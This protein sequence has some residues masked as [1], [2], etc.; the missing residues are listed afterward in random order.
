MSSAQSTIYNIVPIHKSGDLIKTDNYR[1]ISPTSVMVKVYNRMLLNRIKPI[2][3]PLQRTNQY[4]F[5]ETRTTVQQ[6]LALRRL[7]EGVKKKQLSAIIT[8]IALRKAFES[9]HR[10]RLMRIL[11]ADGIPKPIIDSVSAMYA[12]TSAKVMSPDGVTE[13]FPILAG[14]LQGDTLV[15]YLSII[16]L[17]YTLRRAIEGRKEQLG[18]TVTPRKR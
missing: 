13:P 6:V 3:G 1:G 12:N 4:E 14:V 8:F 16:A 10:D 17:D 18:F 7:V 11:D 9:I 15:P 5:R 2:L